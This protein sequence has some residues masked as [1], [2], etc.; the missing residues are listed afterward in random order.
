V[1]NP[2]L[3]YK[4]LNDFDKDMVHLLKEHKILSSFQGK[5]LNMD[6]A[7]KTIIFERNNLI[8]IF[9]WHQGNSVPNYKFNSIGKGTYQT[10]LCSDDIKYGGFGRV[11]TS[12][13]HK[14][15]ENDLLSIYLPSRTAI[16]LK[17][18]N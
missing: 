8:F 17:K 11:D 14:T 13:L 12:I 1:D 6:E 3:K 4:F 2:K 15:L 5:Q 9:N 18:I 7:N 16:I 10:I